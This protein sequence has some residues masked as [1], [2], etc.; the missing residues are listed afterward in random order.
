MTCPGCGAEMNHH[1]DKL[2]CGDDGEQIE[3]FH[4]CPACGSVG[5]RIAE[6]QVS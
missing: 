4:Q 1:A 3:E 5:S 6:E 2:V